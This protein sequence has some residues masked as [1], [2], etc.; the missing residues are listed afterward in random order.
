MSDLNGAGI[1][2]LVSDYLSDLAERAVQW[3]GRNLQFF[4]PLSPRSPLPVRR[5]I[6][7]AIELALLCRVWTKL[8]P[9]NDVLYEATALLEKIWAR[10][11]FPLLIDMH[12]GAYADIHRLT[13]A[14]LA[15]VGAR[16]DLREAALARL[17]ADGYLLPLA[18]SPYRQL[19]VRYFAD[20]AKAEHGMEPYRDL[21]GNSLLARLPA[22][23]VGQNEAYLLTHAVFYLSDFGRCDLDL[24]SD[25][26]DRAERFTRSML[27]SC[28]RQNLWDLTA[29]LIVATALLGRGSADSPS[30]QAGI[31]CLAR[32][33]LDNGAIPGASAADRALP[34]QTTAE[35]FCKAYHTTLV[36]V[37]M[38]LIVG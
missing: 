27:D 30:G 32:A 35:F 2:T 12:G 24:P 33:Q 15:P 5:S 14:A 4:D 9:A 29:E 13:Y 10:P 20:L 21:A 19:E 6:R 25:V 22:S 31:Q 26:R 11:E 38:A 8:K 3:L 16:E 18:K 7:A 23:P 37:M 36:T 1:P 34:S 28:V 17:N